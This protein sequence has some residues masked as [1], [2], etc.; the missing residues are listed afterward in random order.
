ELASREGVAADDVDGDQ[1]GPPAGASDPRVAGGAGGAPLAEGGLGVLRAD[2]RPAQ[3]P[4]PL[5]PPGGAGPENEGEP[6]GAGVQPG[7]IAQPL[8]AVPDQDAPESPGDEPAR[9]RHGEDHRG[10]RGQD[11]SGPDGV[12]PGVQPPERDGQA[13]EDEEFGAPP[14]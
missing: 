14:P 4:S 6:P 11:D 8:E 3:H 9:V 12:G 7:L 2:A 1:V 10:G 13:R 5:P